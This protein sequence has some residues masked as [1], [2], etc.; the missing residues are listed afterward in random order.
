MRIVVSGTHGSGKSTLI[1]AFAARHPEYAV[2]GDPY[3][4]LDDDR[5]SELDA[6]LFAAQLAIVAERLGDADAPP[7]LISERGPLDFVAYLDALNALARRGRSSAAVRR[8]VDVARII[9][10]RMDLLVL[11]PLEDNDPISMSDDEDLE[12]RAA[13]NDSL[14][15]FAGDPDLAG[16]RVIEIAGTPNARLEQLEAAVFSTR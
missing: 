14:L 8:A 5:F 11:L 7:R 13:M 6:S 16:E 4:D 9:A 1:S 15:E 2:M 3:E 10:P 12:L